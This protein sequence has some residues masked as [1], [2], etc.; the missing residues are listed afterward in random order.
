M[1]LAY[2]RFT[3]SGVK[4]MS[5]KNLKKVFLGITGLFLL[6]V[7]PVS[8]EKWSQRY[9]N[10]LPDSAFAV[11][12]VTPD[13]KI[14]RHLPHHN[15]EGE[16]DIPHLKSAL[17]RIH[18][19][20]WIDPENFYKAK[21]HLEQHYQ[22]YNQGKAVAQ[23]NWKGSGGWGKENQYTNMFDPKTIET[24]SG[25]VIRVGR[26][27]P[28]E[29]MSRG[30]YLLLKTNKETISVHLGPAWFIENQ[31][32]KIEPQDRVEVKGSRATFRGKPIII[33]IEIKKGD[34]ILKL[35]DENGLPFWSGYRRR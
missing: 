27:V 31:D 4:N 16:V 23:M 29:G 28:F 35:R 2:W 26:I 33:A 17:G 8:A 12:E 15:L 5:A 3:L 9:I 34:T 20:K 6:Y 21:A 7:S 18:Q 25:K 11:I 1:D 32:I 19:V 14:V 22:A 24:I 10:S 30:V 13:G